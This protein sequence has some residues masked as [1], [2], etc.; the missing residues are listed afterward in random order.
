MTAPIAVGTYTLDI[1]IAPNTGGEERI[2]Y[3]GKR[4]SD[5]IFDGS[6][7]PYF[8][9]N[10]GGVKRGTAWNIYYLLNVAS[11]KEVRLYEGEYDGID[12]SCGRGLKIGI[13]RGEVEARFKL[14]DVNK[15]GLKDIV[16][17]VT[18]ID[19]ST[20]RIY[21]YQKVFLAQE[22]GFKLSKDTNDQ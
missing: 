6:G 3:G 15:D 14:A 16:F 1:S 20:S 2:L 10:Y 18:E 19:C 9:T 17:D 11:L 7:S 5:L 4:V 22:H 21:T 13:E 12:G 8:L